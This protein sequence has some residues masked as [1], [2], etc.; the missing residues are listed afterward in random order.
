M[1][2]KSGNQLGSFVKIIKFKGC[3][4]IRF[5]HTE[6]IAD[7]MFY[8]AKYRFS[9]VNTKGIDTVMLTSNMRHV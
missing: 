4:H 3:M 8:F 9:L 5:M 2:M 1:H 6:K 7:P